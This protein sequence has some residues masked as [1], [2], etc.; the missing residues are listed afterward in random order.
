MSTK[1]ISRR[2]KLHFRVRRN[3]ATRE[4]SN[5]PK[6]LKNTRS[7]CPSF[8]DSTSYVIRLGK[9][10]CLG[11]EVEKGQSRLIK[12]LPPHFLMT[13]LMN[14]QPRSPHSKFYRAW[15]VMLSELEGIEEMLSEMLDLGEVEG[16]VNAVKLREVGCLLVSPSKFI[17]VV[18]LA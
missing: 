3:D 5:S 11:W 8:F 12:G 1:Q 2:G 6:P 18:Q 14:F 10:I 7:I 16:R 15:T 9:L 13:T 17:R 4:L